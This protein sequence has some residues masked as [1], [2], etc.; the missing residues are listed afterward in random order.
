MQRISLTYY[1]KGMRRDIEGWIRACER[2]GCGLHNPLPQ[3]QTRSAQYTGP[4][5]IKAFE[6]ISMDVIGPFPKPE[7]GN[8]Y[9]FTITDLATR[10]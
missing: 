4:T 10:W 8:V 5:N 6:R 3:N 2:I 1:W 7:D 9:L